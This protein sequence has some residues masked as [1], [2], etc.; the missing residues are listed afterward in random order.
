MSIIL[1]KIVS[2]ESNSSFS[3]TPFC[4]IAYSSLKQLTGG[5]LAG[6]EYV[7][8]SGMLQV[9]AFLYE[10][11]AVLGRAR[12]EDLIKI[13]AALSSSGQ[14]YNLWEL[15][16]ALKSRLENTSRQCRSL[17]TFYL[18]G[19]M[20]TLNL[21]FTVRGMKQAHSELRALGEG[22]PYFDAAGAEGLILGS[23]FPDLTQKLY[24][25]RFDS[26]NRMVREMKAHG[27][28]SPEESEQSNINERERQVLHL[29]E[30]YLA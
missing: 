20:E 29:F 5:G 18:D 3:V 8:L 16:W 11:A 9:C 15:R 17:Y 24:N 14:E 28:I 12:R 19:T 4:Q 23:S 25:K 1:A 13:L 30:E 27:V 22:Q 7:R 10:T 2:V 21:D 26:R 6:R